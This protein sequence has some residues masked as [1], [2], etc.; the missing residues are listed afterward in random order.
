[1]AWADPN[2]GAAWR[3]ANKGY[4]RRWALAKNYGITPED[5]DQLLDKQGGGCAICG[6]EP[7]T[8]KHGL[9]HVDHDHATSEIRGLLCFSCNVALGAFKDDTPRIARAIS[10]LKGIL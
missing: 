1:M 9:L 5:Y 8:Q 6:D 4:F 3:K 10:Y 2:K 7:W